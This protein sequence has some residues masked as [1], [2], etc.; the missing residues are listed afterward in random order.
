MLI[1]KIYVDM[2]EELQRA[3]QQFEMADIH[4]KMIEENYPELLEI[5]GYK[6]FRSDFA[7]LIRY[8]NLSFMGFAIVSMERACEKLEKQDTDGDKEL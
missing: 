4:R 1:K 2:L 3:A 8:L 5:D 6:K 7:E